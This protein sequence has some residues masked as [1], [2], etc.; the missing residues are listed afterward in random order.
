MFDKFDEEYTL[1]EETPSVTERQKAPLIGY[2]L[3]SETSK[4]M[5]PRLL[6]RGPQKKM[7]YFF[8]V[9]LGELSPKTTEGV[10]LL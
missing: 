6:P 5:I 10:A 4:H 2:L 1:R 7:Q 8:G 3:A 9:G